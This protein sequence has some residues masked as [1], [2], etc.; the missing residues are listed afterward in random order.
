MK[1]LLCI[2][3]LSFII[4]FG[5]KQKS[6]NYQ[7]TSETKTE[8]NH[9]DSTFLQTILP[10]PDS[11]DSPSNHTLFPGGDTLSLRLEMSNKKKHI[12]I[13]INISSGKELFATLS[14]NDKKAN[15]RISQIG[16]PDGSFDGPFGRNLQHKI[17]TQ[18]SYKI[19]VGQNM[20]AGDP[21]VGDFI[22]KIWVK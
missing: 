10:P 4:L 22:L 11:K 16:F 12:E 1:N 20:M 21:W 18:G 2:F 3:T 8:N 7:E 5:C 13:S 6:I 14:S 15:I 9:Q 19:I 17:K